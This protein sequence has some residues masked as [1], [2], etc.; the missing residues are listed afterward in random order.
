M[1]DESSKFT[2]SEAQLSELTTLLREEGAIGQDVV[3]DSFL[4]AGG[5]GSVFRLRGG[6]LDGK[7][8]KLHVWY[9]EGHQRHGDYDREMEV[10]D[11]L[12]PVVGELTN[13]GVGI[14]APLAHGKFS[15]D[16]RRKKIS[17]AGGRDFFAWNTMELLPGASTNSRRIDYELEAHEKQRLGQNIGDVL[18]I[19]HRSTDKIVRRYRWRW[20]KPKMIAKVRP[21]E[22][23]LFK[24]TQN[25]LGKPGGPADLTRCDASLGASSTDVETVMK[26]CSREILSGFRRAG[27]NEFFRNIINLGGLLP[28]LKSRYVLAHGDA[29][30]ANLMLGGNGNKTDVTAVID[31]GQPRHTLAEFELA[32]LGAVGSVLQYAIRRYEDASGRKL[33]HRLVYAAAAAN[34][35]HWMQESIKAQD[36]LKMTTDPDKYDRFI[37]RRQSAIE[38][39][40]ICLNRHGMEGMRP[41]V[42]RLRVAHGYPRL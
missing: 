37:L 31:W 13:S 40:E 34:A 6:A 4:A 28:I 18:A 1:S 41:V 32:H 16:G 22:E 25:M 9:P 2:Y 35:Y 36:H 38:M 8:I 24:Q 26:V 10:F 23:F 30:L 29:N 5:S 39:M 14:P 42:N 12:Q 3:V 19:L 17:A 15:D 20:N 27:W 21:A 11:T 7:L 33:D